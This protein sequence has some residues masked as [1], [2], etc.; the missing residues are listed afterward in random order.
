MS[1]N[2]PARERPVLD[3]RRAGVLLHPTSLPSGDLGID[4]V[5][6]LDFLQEQGFSAWQMLPLGPAGPNGSPYSPDSAFA[7]NPRL[8]PAEL[9]SSEWRTVNWSSFAGG[10]PTGW[11]AMRSSAP[12]GERRG[13][14]RGGN[15]RGL[16]ASVTRMR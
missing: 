14:V 3:R 16:C 1:D 11:K 5:R 4:A 7:G 8:I 13:I 6:F 9:R 10:R 2:V 12:F 15:G